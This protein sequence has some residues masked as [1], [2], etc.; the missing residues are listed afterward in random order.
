MTMNCKM[1]V[2]A[3][4]L[5]LPGLAG[6][7]TA[8]QIME[9]FENQKL[10]ALQ[11]YVRAN[12][13]ADDVSAAT[14]AVIE[15]LVRLGREKDALPLLVKKYDRLSAQKD[16]ALPQ[17]F[18]EVI[19][20][21]AELHSKTGQRQ[22]GEAF[23]ERVKKDFAAHEDAERVAQAVAQLQT[24]LGAPQIGDRL[25]IK[26]TATDQREVDLAKLK[27]KVVLV[28][29]WASWCGPCVREMPNVVRAYEQFH[30]QGFEIIGISLDEDKA[31][32]E[33]FVAA[34]KLAWP[35]FFDGK[36]WENEW[37]RQY[38]IQGI[39]ATFLIAKDGTIAATNVRGE[40]LAKKVAELLAAK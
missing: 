40:E 3:G 23:L 19:A 5:A 25:A 37:V 8:Q 22:E 1:L 27:G 35:Q 28:D 14:D 24:M 33:R 7:E 38:G 9:R 29:F 30:D 4:L 2:W 18:G 34:R 15:G 21:V 12:P 10:A 16:V 20:P 26:F 36:G 6:A 31:A 13:Q 39:P 17:L 11:E 32:F